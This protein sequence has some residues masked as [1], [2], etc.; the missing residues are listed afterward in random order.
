MTTAHIRSGDTVLILGTGGVSIFGLQFAKP[1]GARVIITSSSDEKLERAKALG[2][3]Y[4]INYT[5]DVEW[6][7][8]VLRLTNGKGVNVVLETAGAG[9]L[10]QSLSSI[11]SHG[12][13]SLI[14]ILT[15]ITTQ[16]N[17]LPILAQNIRVQGINVGSVAMLKEM[18]QAI[19]KNAIK[20]VIDRVFPFEQSREALR[21]MESGRHLGK[22]IISS[23]EGGE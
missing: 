10:S 11:R 2:A 22:I 5:K 7:R 19:A 15:G 14:G 12:Q 1:N 23:I 20:P 21:Y 16:I 6:S 3:D 8:E 9:T 17:I 13:V 4:T 18:I